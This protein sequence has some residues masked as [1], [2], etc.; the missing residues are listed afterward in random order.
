[1]YNVQAEVEL[2]LEVP[3][4]VQGRGDGSLD[5]STQNQLDR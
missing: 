4:E 3:A 1:M 2:R 5:A